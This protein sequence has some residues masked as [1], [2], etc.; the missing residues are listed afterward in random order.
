MNKQTKEVVI[1]KV[2][3][4][5]FIIKEVEGQDVNKRSRKRELI[6]AR[7]IYFFILREREGMGLQK[8][9]NTVKMDHASV[10][11]GCRKITDWI[12]IDLKF[13]NRYL[14]VLATYSKHVYGA[15]AESKILSKIQLTKLPDHYIEIEK[16]PI[17]INSAYAKLHTLIDE[18][19][20]NKADDLLMRVEAIYN[21][22][23]S[24]LKRNR[25]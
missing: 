17:K 8:I 23:I 21:M 24:D 14:K 18:T 9:G 25:I 12:E 1:N 15:K 5:K 10:L 3:L 2:E 4:L 11:Y 7:F 22:M 6:E 19:P 13:K 20:E 16:K